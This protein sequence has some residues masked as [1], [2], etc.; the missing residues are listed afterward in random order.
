VGNKSAQGT[1]A[2]RLRYLMWREMIRIGTEK[3]VIYQ[4]FNEKTKNTVLNRKSARHINHE[5]ALWFTPDLPPLNTTEMIYVLKL[6][7]S[8]S[9][10]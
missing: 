2:T 6:P 4:I 8:F 1:A 5:G 7:R 10:Y 3:F 9:I